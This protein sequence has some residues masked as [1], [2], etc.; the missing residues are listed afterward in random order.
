[1]KGKVKI[2]MIEYVENMPKDFPGKL[3]STDT[4]IM[5]ASNGLFDEGQGKKLDQERA[6]AYH[7]MVTKALFLCKRARP[8]IHPTIAVLCTRVH[9]DANKADW[10]KSD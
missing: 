3:K 1:V 8:D 5:P 10:A 9:K 6:D 2:G 4:A 7:M